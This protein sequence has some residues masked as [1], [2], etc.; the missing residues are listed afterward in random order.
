MTLEETAM[1]TDNKYYKEFD[2]NCRQLN[3]TEIYKPTN[4]SQY[5]RFLLLLQEKNIACK[6]YMDEH[7]CVFEIRFR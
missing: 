2:Y 4:K 5:K 6:G 1:T 3:L 7:N